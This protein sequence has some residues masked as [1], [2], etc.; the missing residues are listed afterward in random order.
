MVE[1]NQG[2]EGN[3]PQEDIIDLTHLVLKLQ[4]ENE[5]LNDTVSNQQIELD[6]F[7]N[8]IRH[9]RNQD[10][11]LPDI[12]SIDIFGQVIPLNNQ[13][14]GDHITYVDFQKRYDLQER[15]KRAISDSKQD[16]AANLEANKRRAGV[17]VM[18]VSGHSITDATLAAYVHQ[19]FLTAALYELSYHGEIT[20]KL[21]EK[22]NTRIYNS[23]PTGKFVTV[24]Y[25]EIHSTGKF[26]FVC[27]G[28]P[29]PLFFSAKHDRLIPIDRSKI[30]VFYPLGLSPNSN[31]IDSN[32]YQPTLPFESQ[33][34][35]NEIGMMGKG[36]ILFLYTDG[37]SEHE[38]GSSKYT[39]SALEA[40]IRKSKH[41]KARQIY[42]AIMQDF[43]DYGQPIDDVTLVVIKKTD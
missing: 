14:G 33:Y 27:A 11:E 20:K 18:D 8:F 40:T 35:V 30:E 5:L 41:L 4:K 12:P 10:E 23:I 6:N 29:I 7:S 42:E 39:D 28:H 43:T 1:N 36:D 3:M 34:V 17:M 16:I 21:F 15:I 24:I 2:V 38:K 9:L 13:C 32:L 19:A 26:R 22:L 25:G 37:F 31:H